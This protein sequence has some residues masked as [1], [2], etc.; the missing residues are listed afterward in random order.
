MRKILV[1]FLMFAL[2]ASF[3]TAKVDKDKPEN[4]NPTCA[5]IGDYDNELKIDPPVSGTY[6]G[7]TLT[8][9]DESEPVYFDW[10]STF[11]IDAVISKGG[12][13]ANVYYYDPAA[14]SDTGLVSPNN[15]NGKPAGL[16][17]VVFCWDDPEEVPEFGVVAGGLALIGALGIFAFTRRH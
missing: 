7:I 10:S 3:A 5:D 14:L 8:L 12:N 13:D 16:S 4:W 6:D 2:I 9:D 17:H 15:P 11:P 1:L